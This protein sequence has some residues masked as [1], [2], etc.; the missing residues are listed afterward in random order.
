MFGHLWWIHI[1]TAHFS[2]QEAYIEGTLSCLC[3]TSTLAAGV[4]LPAKRVIL[5][6][7]YVGVEFLTPARYRQMIGRAGRAGLDTSGMFVSYPQVSLGTRDTLLSSIFI[8]R[9][10]LPLDIRV[11]VRSSSRRE[12]SNL[13]SF[14][15][16][17]GGFE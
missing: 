13:Q 8:A 4:N 9:G 16:K 7:P 17:S 5:K 1:H 15:E 11:F 14:D 3:C 10:D 2:T 6:S 12:Y